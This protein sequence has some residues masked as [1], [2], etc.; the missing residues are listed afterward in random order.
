MLQGNVLI[1]LFS[2]GVLFFFLGWGIYSSPDIKYRNYEKCYASR[3]IENRCIGIDI[4]GLNRE[5][6][7]TDLCLVKRHLLSEDLGLEGRVYIKKDR[8][9]NYSYCERFDDIGL[10]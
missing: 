8:S 4:S 3:L 2:L 10:L 5:Y 6:L 9:F 1:G 7:I